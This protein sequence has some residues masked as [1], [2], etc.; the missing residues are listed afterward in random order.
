M[1]FKNFFS[2]APSLLLVVL[3]SSTASAATSLTWDTVASDS[4]ITGGA[5]NWTTSTTTWTADAGVTNIAWNNA[6]NDTATFQGTAGT[7]T[8]TEPITTGGITFSTASYIVTGN[9]LTFGAATNTVTNAGAATISSSIAGTTGFTKA[10][11]GTLTLGGG[12]GDTNANTESGKITAS[13]G[14]LTLSKA[15]GTDA[16]AGSLDLTGATITWSRANQIKDTS[17]IAVSGTGAIATAFTDTV[18]NITTTGNTTKFNPGSGS[19]VTVTGTLSITGSNGVTNTNF[20]SLA[21][22]SA[23]SSLT[24]GSL[25][26]SDAY[27]GVGQGNATFTS[28]VNLN[29]GLTGAN[30]NSVPGDTNARLVLAGTGT[31]DHTFNVSS[32]ITTLGPLMTQTSGTTG[33]LTKTGA[34]V[35][36]I[37]RPVTYTGGTTVS[38]GTLA[39][40]AGGTNQWTSADIDTFQTTAPFATGTFFGIDTTGGAFTYA[41]GIAGDRGF[42]K[43][44]TNTLTLTGTSSYT[45][46]TR[47]AGG[48]LALG[49]GNLLPITPL[50]FTGTSTLNTGGFSQSFSGLSVGST[51]TGTLNG[52]GNVTVSGSNVSIGG[53]ASGDS[54]TLTTTG[55]GMFIYDN[56]SGSFSVGGNTDA[57]GASGTVNLAPNSQL[58]TGTFFIGRDVSLAHG[59][60]STH[61]GTVNMNQATTFYVGTLAV[62][63]SSKLNGTLK[64]TSGLTSPTV[65]IRGT[66]GGTSR[67]TVNIA[68]AGNS[69]YQ[70]ATGLADFTGGTLDALIGTMNIGQVTGNT[71][72][73]TGTFRMSGGTLDATSILLGARTGSGTGV[74]SGTFQITGGTA[75][76]STITFVP[77]IGSG[78]GTNTAILNLNGGTLAAQTVQP[79]TGSASRT[80]NWNSGTITTY[81]AITDLTLGAVDVKLA[82]TGTHS[83][84]IPTGRSATVNAVIGDATTGGSLQKD[85]AGTLT[86]TAANTYT[87]DTTVNAGT[88]SLSQAGLA[89]TANLSI[90]TGATVTLGFG[91]TDTV[92]KLFIGGVQKNAGVWGAPGSGAPNTDA[93][94]AG[95]GTLTVTT[96]ASGYSTWATLQGLGP[97]NNAKDANPDNDGL[98]NLAEFAFDDTPLSGVSSGKIASRVVTIGGAKVLTLTIPVRDD[99]LTTTFSGSPTLVSNAVD[100]F[101]YE[102]SGSTDL[103]STPVTVIELTDANATAIQNTLPILSTGWTYRTF[104]TSGT[105][106]D[107][108]KAFLRAKV[109]E[110]P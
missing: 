82:A 46:A 69:S 28:T 14:S 93:A 38:A 36:S 109:S 52:S 99:A 8:L 71:R 106:N 50:A 78:T 63:G 102:V 74:A 97:S 10:G 61:T 56:A 35:L 100:G 32:G 1:K 19:N 40:G 95:T 81:D 86:L 39:V 43:V 51:F 27:F 105:V 67:A 44:G 7:V 29:G 110:T 91:G 6:N 76:V 58:I 34:G 12:S 79:G 84:D 101:H 108:P 62:A 107:A 94:L 54:A 25:A 53:T 2:L 98:N 31:H 92:A 104:R 66:T 83:F 26:L 89:D 37:S 17:N 9:T 96:S 103:G 75:K 68:T 57:G 16:I 60:N 87:G 73:S 55:L 33:S 48:T 30:T 65:Q 21:S 70:N 22:N 47:I 23:N 4:A 5:G 3:V 18:A 88:L 15:A 13:A 80:L 85:G 64:F 24:L 59:S 41:T 42:A 49:A 11:A 20:F 90:A 77:A 72:N 45:G